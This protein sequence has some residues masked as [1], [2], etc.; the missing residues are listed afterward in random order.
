MSPGTA[1]IRPPMTAA[2]ARYAPADHTVGH[3]PSKPARSASGAPTPKAM[4]NAI[5]IGWSGC[6]FT[7]AVLRMFPLPARFHR[8]RVP[9]TTSAADELRVERDLGRGEQL[10]HR[11]VPL[12][13]LR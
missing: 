13:S 11:A 6:P 10:R 3:A 9:T 2:V 8:Q 1:A 5:R 7:C 4:G 12:G